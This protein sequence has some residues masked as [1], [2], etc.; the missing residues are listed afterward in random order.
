MWLMVSGSWQDRELVYRVV[1]EQDRR[2][3]AVLFSRE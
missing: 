3:V 1:K 2:I